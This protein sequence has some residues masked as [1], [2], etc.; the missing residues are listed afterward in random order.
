MSEHAREVAA[1]GAEQGGAALAVGSGLM[2]WLGE[3]HD[4]IAS[5]GVIA[6]VLIGALGFFREL[7]FQPPALLARFTNERAER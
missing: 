3:N 7:V 4:A 6:G 2:K 1:K 5:I